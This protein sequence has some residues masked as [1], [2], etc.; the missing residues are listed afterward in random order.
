MLRAGKI[1]FQ[2]TD[3]QLRASEDPYIRR[4]IKASEV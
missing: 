4:F 2:G 3:D 1:I